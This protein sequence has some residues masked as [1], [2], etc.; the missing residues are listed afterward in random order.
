MKGDFPDANLTTSEIAA[1]TGDSTISKPPAIIRSTGAQRRAPVE[2]RA[3]MP[4]AVSVRRKAGVLIDVNAE[5][6]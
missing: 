5:S 3:E 1:S 2:T 4:I 6:E